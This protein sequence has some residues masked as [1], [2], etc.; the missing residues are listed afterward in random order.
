MNN[1][2]KTTSAKKSQERKKTNY[3]V[4]VFLFALSLFSININAQEKE[5]VS[6]IKG[7]NELKINGL[8]L[9]AGGAEITYERILSDETA[10]GLSIA[11][12][13]D[14]DNFYNFGAFPYYRF[15][16]G[17]KRAGGFFVEGNGAV[18]VDQFEKEVTITTNGN[19]GS[20]NIND[21]GDLKTRFGLGIAVGGKFLSR[22]GWIGELSLGFGRVFGVENDA[23]KVYTRA[24]ITIGKRF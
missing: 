9:V 17:K 7:N 3:F 16:F 22:N 14:N 6:Q 18:L 8:Y 12:D 4:P 11:F 24:G 10:L 15:Y 19:N 13:I 5:E 21:I 20:I 1:Y 2:L 23:S